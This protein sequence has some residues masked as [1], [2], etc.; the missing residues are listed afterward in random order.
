MLKFINSRV[1]RGIAI[2]SMCLP[3]T[4]LPPLWQVIGPNQELLISTPFGDTQPFI[5]PADGDYTI[6]ID[7]YPHAT[8]NT[9]YAFRLKPTILAGPFTIDLENRGGVSYGYD[10]VFSQLTSIIDELGHQ[11]LFEVDPLNGNTLSSRRV[12]GAMDTDASGDDLVTLYSYTPS[13]LLASMI[14]PLGRVITYAYDDRDRLV[15]MVAAVGTDDEATTRFEYDDAGNQTA[16]IDANGNR[17][18]FQYDSM[19]RVTV[20]AEAD[21]DGDGPLPQPTTTFSYDLA[22]NLLTSTDAENSTV[23]YVYDERDQLVSVVDALDQVTQYVYDPVGNLRETK[24]PLGNTTVNSYDGRNRL[25]RSGDP[26]GGVTRYGYDTDNNLVSLIDPVGNETQFVYDARD[27]MTEEIDPLGNSTFYAYDAAN[28]LIGKTDRNERI[29]TFAYDDLDRLV[30]ETWI[31]PDGTTIVNTINYAYDKVSSLLAVSD[32]YSHLTYTYDSLNRVKT[33]DNAG[34]PDAP[35]VVLTYTYDAF[36]NVL[37]VSDVINSVAGAVTGY[38]YDRLNRATTIRQSGNEVSEKVVDFVF[39]EIG[40]YDQILRYS[41]F[42]RANLVVETD[43]GYDEINR[44]VDLDHTN[45]SDEV[46]AFFD[47]V[48]DD[49]SRIAQITDINGVTDFSY[50]DRSQLTGADRSDTDTRVDETYQYDANGNRI[51]SHLH[52]NGYVTGPGNRLLSDGTHDYEYDDEGNMVRL[53]NI[54]TGEYRV[55]KWDHRNRMLSVTDWNAD[56]DEIN[57]A[58]FT[59]DGINR[60][61]RRSIDTDGAGPLPASKLDFAYDGIDVI[62]DLSTTGVILDRYLHGLGVDQLL[63]V[64][65]TSSS[66]FALNDH[67]GS[68]VGSLDVVSGITDHVYYDSFGGS[69]DVITRFGFTGRESEFRL[70]LQYNRGRYYDPNIGV[71]I[72]DDPIGFAGNDSNLSRYVGND[73]INNTDPT[74]ESLSKVIT[75]FLV[76]LA[77]LQSQTPPPDSATPQTPRIETP[78]GYTEDQK[79]R[80]K[81]NRDMKSQNNKPGGNSKPKEPTLKDKFNKKSGVGGTGSSL[82]VVPPNLMFEFDRILGCNPNDPV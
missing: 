64:S 59:H 79:R 8:D 13:G 58:R 44:L 34:T 46:L 54:E 15:T 5:L 66:E 6:V 53:T 27:R 72:S 45:A 29:T 78:D 63:A 61:I 60:R 22:G 74:G 12:V 3:T 26:D 18:E 33:V 76:G 71:F 19:N 10:S 14:D 2:S 67:L 51:S 7:G 16:V 37:S 75:Q 31:D 68:I 23:T 35:N 73:P 41:D 47:Y 4:T 32:E 1:L 65:N 39:N 25:V 28:N 50:D 11:T 77:L 48:Y 20:I 55:F 30:G 24:D 57:T 21:P 40:Q 70:E 17:T 80:D 52:G 62:L 69:D 82:I 81:L 36:G 43:Y 49:A 9:D 42:E 38:E 56:G